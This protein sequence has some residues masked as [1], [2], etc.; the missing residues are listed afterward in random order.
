MYRTNQVAGSNRMI[1]PDDI[2]L[3]ILTYDSEKAEAWF[4]ILSEAEKCRLSTFK[5]PKRRQEYLLGRVA[6]RTLLAE[7]SG[8]SLSDVCLEVNPDGSLHVPG[9][10]YHI[11]I[12]H[13]GRLA[14][15]AIGFRPLGVD[16]ERIAPRHPEI[17]RFILHPSEERIIERLRLERNEALI[18]IWTIK[19]AT[20][21]ALR[22][23]FRLSPKKLRAEI[24][25]E[26]STATV[27]EK[28]GQQ[29]RVP[30]TLFDGHYLALSFSERQETGSFTV[31]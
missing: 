16:L 5:A 24:D 26:A 19:E 10:K 20:L 6:A 9:S 14:V 12:A 21:K 2:S 8:L 31:G 29:W 22:T 23:G 11:S 25:L 28:S 3:R 1:L 18:L 30:F 4:S 13:T 15:A 27:F 7:R 17:S